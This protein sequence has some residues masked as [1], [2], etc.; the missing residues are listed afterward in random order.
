MK[1]GNLKWPIKAKVFDIASKYDDV[2]TVNEHKGPITDSLEPLAENSH[3][4]LNWHLHS[5]QLWLKLKYKGSSS[6]M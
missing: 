6:S 4:N 3:V 5:V 2:L 1:Q